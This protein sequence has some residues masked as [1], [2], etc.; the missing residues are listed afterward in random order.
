MKRNEVDWNSYGIGFHSGFEGLVFESALLPNFKEQESLKESIEQ[1]A[2][3]SFVDFKDHEI[4]FVQ[5]TSEIIQPEH[6]GKPYFQHFRWG[7]PDSSVLM[8]EFLFVPG[9]LHITGDLIPL[10]LRPGR[11]TN[12]MQWLL[13]NIKPGARDIN[14][15]VL[16]KRDREMWTDVEFYPRDVSLY[17]LERIREEIFEGKTFQEFKD[18]FFNERRGDE[19]TEEEIQSMWELELSGIKEEMEECS[20]VSELKEWLE[21]TED[22][23]FHNVQEAQSL[24]YE[25]TDDCEMPGMFTG[26]SRVQMITYFGLARFLDKYRK[27]Y[28]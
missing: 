5:G 13:Q 28:L 2:E 21:K 27:V 24:I 1:V 3:R 11:G 9:R 19:E 7:R 8:L 6:R 20:Y 23:Y 10:N 4:T 17:Y 25:V 14:H 15:Y 12:M 18:D 22:F 26:M 16:E